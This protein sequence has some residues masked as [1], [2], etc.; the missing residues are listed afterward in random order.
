MALYYITSKLVK[1][2][3]SNIC[4][5]KL[6]FKVFKIQTCY[7]S[8]MLLLSEKRM[9]DSL[10]Y[11]VNMFYCHLLIKKLISANGLTEQS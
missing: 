1:N 6:I 7:Y 3:I 9:W 11:I 4:F 2:I 10:L 8:D 5:C